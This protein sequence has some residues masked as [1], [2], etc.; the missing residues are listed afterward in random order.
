MFCYFHSFSCTSTLFEFY[1]FLTVLYIFC[2][3][4]H[5]IYHHHHHNLYFPFI[6]FWVHSQGCGNIQVE[7]YKKNIECGT[8]QSSNNNTINRTMDSS[9]QPFWQLKI[10][11]KNMIKHDINTISGQHPERIKRFSIETYG[12]SRFG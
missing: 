3:N 12:K 2:S 6:H 8:I 5:T 1:I 9:I 11:F 4:T 10:L 7:S